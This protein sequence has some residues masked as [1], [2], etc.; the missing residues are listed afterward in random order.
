MADKYVNLY[1]MSRIVQIAKEVSNAVLANSNYTWDYNDFTICVTCAVVADLLIEREIE[2]CALYKD[3][4][5]AAIEISL[6]NR[7]IDD[8]LSVASFLFS[9]FLANFGEYDLEDKEGFPMFGFYAFEII[10]ENQIERSHEEFL[11][12]DDDKT[13]YNAFLHILKEAIIKAK[14]GINEAIGINLVIIKK[15]EPTN[16]QIETP[17]N[18]VPTPYKCKQENVAA[19]ES[20]KTHCRRKSKIAMMLI[21]ASMSLLIFFVFFAIPRF[22]V[23]NKEVART[24]NVNTVYY[25]TDSVCYHISRYC[26]G[27][28]FLELSS[29]P[30]EAAEKGYAKCERCYW[31]TDNYGWQYYIG[32]IIIGLAIGFLANICWTKYNNYKKTA[33]QKSIVSKPDGKSIY[34]KHCGKQIDSD[35]TFCRFCGKKQDNYIGLLNTRP[36]KIIA[37]GILVIIVA[38]IIFLPSFIK[39]QE[40]IELIESGIV[41][42]VPNG[43]CYHLYEDCSNM[44]NP[45]EAK[46]IDKAWDYDRC[47]KC[48]KGVEDYG[49]VEG[50]NPQYTVIG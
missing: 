32:A 38:L 42:Y 16:N 48:Y 41:Y 26:A 28:K 14:K 22:T 3:D 46:E 19:T 34:C 23:H 45:R 7:L 24:S 10:T 8:D 5:I 18:I 44:A 11:N 37:G 50:H 12:C 36:K 35:S 2:D 15:S 29:T 20:V 47:S 33:L 9:M 27:G 40:K 4:L 25:N 21:G 13:E 30:Q 31:V 39:R 43:N 49:V 1:P 6:S 17:S